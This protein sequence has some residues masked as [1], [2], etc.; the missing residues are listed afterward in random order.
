VRDGE[1]SDRLSSEFGKQSTALDLVG[2]GVDKR[3]GSKMVRVNSSLSNFDRNGLMNLPTFEDYWLRKRK[4]PID[5]KGKHELEPSLMTS[6]VRSHLRWLQSNKQRRRV[7]KMGCAGMVTIKDDSRHRLRRRT[8]QAMGSEKKLQKIRGS[9]EA[10]TRFRS[11]FVSH[12][13]ARV[14]GCGSRLTESQSPPGSLQAQDA[15]PPCAA[16]KLGQGTG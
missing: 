3:N 8:N 13:G 11:S 4:Q 5:G 10:D 7:N 1:R 16:R 12:F 15:L 9:H 2:L 6:S 14:S